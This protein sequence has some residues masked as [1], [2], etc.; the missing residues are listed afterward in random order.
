M[1]TSP[2]SQ[3]EDDA[4]PMSSLPP[5]PPPPAL[6][7]RPLSNRCPDAVGFAAP[8]EL[9]AELEVALSASADALLCEDTSR[10]VLVGVTA[11]VVVAALESGVGEEL[12]FSWCGVV[13]HCAG[14]GEIE[15]LIRALYATGSGSRIA[16]GLSRDWPGGVPNLAGWVGRVGTF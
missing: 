8:E 11:S 15:Q 1:I 4:K 6:L 7:P 9:L 10:P 13:Q 12:I 16:R 5:P 14:K 3:D 2:L